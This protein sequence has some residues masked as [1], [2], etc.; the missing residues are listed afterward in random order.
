DQFDRAVTTPRSG[1]ATPSAGSA[2]QRTAGD[3]ATER[4]RDLWTATLRPGLARHFEPSAV[5]V[6]VDGLE[7]PARTCRSP[8]NSGQLQ[9]R[10]Q[11]ICTDDSY[12]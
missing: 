8:T 1:V 2:L 4:C 11:D 6:T 9:L 5:H 3:P 12:R 7:K 10:T